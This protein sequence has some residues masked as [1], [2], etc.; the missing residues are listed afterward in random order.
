M[1]G[2]DQEKRFAVVAEVRRKWTE[3]EK[4]AILAVFFHGIGTPFRG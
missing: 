2:Y 1:S 3:A 4:Q